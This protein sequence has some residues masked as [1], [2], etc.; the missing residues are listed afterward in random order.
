M[1]IFCFGR[2]LA[3]AAPLEP[4]EFT[5][6]CFWRIFTIKKPALLLAPVVVIAR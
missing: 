3:D 2:L 4:T 1:T 6:A 5:S